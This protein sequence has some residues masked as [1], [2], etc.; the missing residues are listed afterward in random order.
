MNANRSLRTK[1]LI[2]DM[3]GTMIDN[4]MVHH[5][6]WQR[7]LKSLGLELSIEQVK[8]DIHG[9]NHEIINRL[10]GDKYTA[11]EGEQI[12]REKEAEY[13]ALYIDKIKLLPGLKSFLQR[14]KAVGVPMGIG[15]AAPVEN[16][17]FVL[18]TLGIREYFGALIHSG[19]VKKGKPDPE[20]F[21]KV[22]EQL[23]IPLTDCL[24]FEDSPTGA[25]A[26]ANGNTKSI[27]LTTTHHKKEFDGI[28][29]IQGFLGNFS[30]CSIDPWGDS[31]AFDFNF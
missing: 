29:S 16:M 30:S 13:R 2:F 12:A 1:A 5:H 25:Q 7:K 31:A 24:I 6:A 28:G 8:R 4:M 18:D 19:Q 3:D 27:I 23:N 26:A 10:F 21:K 17:D 22:A 9:V 15:T 20:V 14:A 11:H